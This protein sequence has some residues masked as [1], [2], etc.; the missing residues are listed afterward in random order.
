MNIDEYAAGFSEDPG[1]LD[2]AAFGPVQTAVLEEQRVL[3]TIQ[4]HMRFG[5]ME[6]LDEQDARVRTVAARLVGR[7]EDQ[8]VSQ[9]AT[10]PGLLHTAF[11]LTGG[12]LVSADEYPSLPL[13]LAS[14]ASATGGRV[15][16]VVIESGAGWMT[17]SL[18]QERLTDDVTAVAVSL[19]DW[20]TGYLADLAGIREVI[21]DRLLILDAIQGFGVVD[22][23][24][25]IADVVA[26]GGQKWLH[27]GWGTGFTAFSD[28]ALNRLRP[29]LS[30]PH[31]TTGWPVDVPAVRP[32]A[33]GYQMTRIDP[34]AQAR[35]AVSLDRLT[36][37][38]VAAVQERVTERVERVFAIADEFGLEVESSRD[39]RERA[40][41]V[42]L[43]PAEG[44]LTALSAAL[45][46]HGVTAT[47]RLG[48]ARVSVFASTTDETLDM[49]RDAC[50]S[51]ATLQ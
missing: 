38:G 20:R 7:R 48:V 24:Y 10:T 44:R 13:A 36:A 49:F 1:Y 21:G 9:T 12:V 2:H 30:G 37:V 5:A 51:Y 40:G 27:A 45:H 50:V 35:L 3:G 31:G 34:I 26:T 8:V 39:P 15:Q 43:R 6:T 46:N 18:I 32:G 41:I 11:G 19:V 42:V 25:E 23:P 29:A 47:T 22:A 16:P 4:E 14:A 17:P 28:R 33:A